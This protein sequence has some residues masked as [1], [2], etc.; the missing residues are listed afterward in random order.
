MT[1]LKGSISALLALCTGNLPPTGELSPRR[2]VTRSFDVFF[3]RRLNTRLSKQSRRRWFEMSSP[4]LWHNCNA[5]Q[6]NYWCN[7]LLMFKLHWSYCSNYYMKGKLHHKDYGHNFQFYPSVIFSSRYPA[8][9]TNHTWKHKNNI[10]KES[11]WLK[12]CEGM[13]ILDFWTNW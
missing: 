11:Q 3:D 4:S 5:L 2:P 10:I 7:Y 13:E 6:E 12:F 1:S 9:R 8:V